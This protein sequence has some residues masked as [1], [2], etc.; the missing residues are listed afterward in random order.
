MFHP[1]QNGK[2]DTP[3]PFSISLEEFGDNWDKAF[4]KKK[5]NNENE[6]STIKDDQPKE[7]KS[8]N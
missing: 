5:Q 6:E 3:R 8:T 2:G 7:I 4:S 1:S